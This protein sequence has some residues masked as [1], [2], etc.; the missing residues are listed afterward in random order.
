MG[1]AGFDRKL[2]PGDDAMA[3]WKSGSSY[4]F[5][6]Y[7]LPSP[8]HPNASW[9]GKRATLIAQGWGLAVVY[10]GRQQSGACQHREFSAAQGTTDGQDAIAR[11]QQDGF[12]A[13]TTIFLDVEKL[14]DA[15][16][17]DFQDYF[18]AWIGALLDDPIGYRPGVYC[19]H[20]DANDLFNLAQSA[21]AAHNL[22]GGAPKFWVVRLFNDFSPALDEPT[23]SEIAYANVMQGHISPDPLDNGQPYS[24]TYNGVTLDIDVDVADSANPSG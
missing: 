21:Y 2:Y 18:K 10:V 8:C 19:S 13:G 5:V 9:A 20:L 7:Y 22:P 12:G 14:T 23:R 15:G 24:E 11:A 16:D 6:G 1:F 4:S 17:S 3:A